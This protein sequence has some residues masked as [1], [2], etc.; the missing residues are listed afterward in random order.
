[1][2]SSAFVNPQLPA[3]R[4]I[5]VGVCQYSGE[6][7]DPNLSFYNLRA[8]YYNALTGRFET[9][10]SYAGKTADPATLHKYA[11]ARNNPINRIDPTG[12]DAE[13]EAS[14]YESV[15]LPVVRFLNADPLFKDLLY[16]EAGACLVFQV[17]REFQSGPDTP[18]TA[19]ANTFCYVAEGLGLVAG[20][21][22]PTGKQ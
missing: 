14:I 3:V 9:L 18:A 15:V 10:D 13:E 2:T 1:M 20:L 5:L 19:V 12:N 22:Q 7:L 6:R 11:Y 21:P 8:R 16:I 17:T 4:P